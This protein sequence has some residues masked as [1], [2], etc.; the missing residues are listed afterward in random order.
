MSFALARRKITG[1]QEFQNLKFEYFGT[2]FKNQPG[3]KVLFRSTNVPTSAGPKYRYPDTV[4]VQ[5]L[6]AMYVHPVRSRYPGTVSGHPVRSE[7]PRTVSGHPDRIGPSGY[8][9]TPCPY[10][11]IGLSGRSVRT[12]LL[13]YTDP[14]SVYP[15]YGLDCSGDVPRSH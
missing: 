6:W 7:Y 2:D 10:A 8:V 14:L 12:P 5:D 13:S 9:R 15:P 3:R 11:P 4:S 1:A